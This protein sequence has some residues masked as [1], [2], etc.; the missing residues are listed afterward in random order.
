MGTGDSVN[1]EEN[2]NQENQETEVEQP[3]PR[4]FIDF[5]WFPRND[6]SFSVIARGCL[7]SDCRQ[8][9]A[10]ESGEMAAADLMATI[11]DCCSQ[12]P[13]FIT[14]ELPVLASLFRLV[15]ANGN[16][17]LDPAELSQRLN[18]WRRGYPIAPE[19]LNRLLENDRCYGLSQ[20]PE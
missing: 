12:Q 11:K 9:Q 20:V 6:R 16:Q 4:W 3:L 13:G 17:P 8:R 19:T 1:S 5:D 18:E 15:L 2:D 14:S 7:C 10:E